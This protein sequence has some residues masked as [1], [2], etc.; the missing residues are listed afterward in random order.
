MVLIGTN[1]LSQ[2]ANI[3]M[4]AVTFSLLYFFGKTAASR[5]EK[6]YFTPDIIFTIIYLYDFL[7]NILL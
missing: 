5:N 1:M 2:A 6:Y 3:I 7:N 4:N